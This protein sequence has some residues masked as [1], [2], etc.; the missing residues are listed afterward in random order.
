MEKSFLS[1]KT[2]L[3]NPRV[4]LILS[5]I[6]LR[7]LIGLPPI[8]SEEPHRENGGGAGVCGTTPAAH[9]LLM[10]HLHSAFLWLAPSLAI[11]IEW[12]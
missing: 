6:C 3:Q 10:L 2:K 12:H 8:T 1:H 5:Q 11:C 9:A 4:W 7:Y